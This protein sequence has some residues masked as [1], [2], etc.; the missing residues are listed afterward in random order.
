MI[1]L[2]A[3]GPAF[4][5]VD[6]SP[7]VTKMHFFRDQISTLDIIIFSQIGAFTFAHFDNATS[8]IVRQYKNLVEFAQNIQSEYYP[9]L[10]TNS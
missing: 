8:R 3:F 9:H 4:G 7:F 2:Y 6:P 5:L 10:S 1:K